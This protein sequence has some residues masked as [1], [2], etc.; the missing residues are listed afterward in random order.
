M[1]LIPGKYRFKRSTSEVGRIQN[2]ST[3]PNTQEG[4]DELLMA[5]RELESTAERQIIFDFLSCRH[6]ATT[7]STITNYE[8]TSEP[9][10][11]SEHSRM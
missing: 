6:G 9:P 8:S 4:A 10:M 11:P 2:S 3:N 1:Q 5:W 7:G